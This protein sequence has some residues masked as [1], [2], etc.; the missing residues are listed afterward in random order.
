MNN[1]DLNLLQYLLEFQKTGSLSKT[2]ENLSISQPAVSK[3]MQ[4]LEEELGIPLFERGKNKLTLNDNGKIVC[5]YGK[6]ILEIQGN[7]LSFAKEIQ[8]GSEEVLIGMCAPGPLFYY[9][10][11]LEKGSAFGRFVAEI[12]KDEESLKKGL[13]NGKYDLIFLSSPMSKP[14]YLSKKVFAEKLFVSL[15]KEHFLSR[16]KDKIF[17]S[18]L[19]GQTF[20]LDARVG[21][22]DQVVR[23]KLPKS[24]FIVQEDPEALK[25]M[26]EHSSLLAFQS[27]LTLKQGQDQN[28]IAIPLSDKEA[29][30]SFYLT[31]KENWV[32]CYKEFFE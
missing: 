13:F 7:I 14:G 32:H 27:S 15:P 19:D 6:D 21:Y 25:E 22:W 17:L 28:R 20:L 26:R 4:R 10:D 23:A 11:I 9:K 18:D 12:D 31:I 8:E 24:R 29:S 16:A 3:A 1:F 30:L 2:G 5:E